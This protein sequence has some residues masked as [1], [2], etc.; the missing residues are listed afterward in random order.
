MSLCPA[1]LL[2]LEVTGD[3][4]ISIALSLTDRYNPFFKIGTFHG[5]LRMFLNMSL[6]GFALL[7][8]VIFDI[9]FSLTTNG[10]FSG[11]VSQKNMLNLLVTGIPFKHHKPETK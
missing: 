9:S 10:H 3:I 11:I 2:K 6:K 1:V 4:S 7:R 5:I 8:P